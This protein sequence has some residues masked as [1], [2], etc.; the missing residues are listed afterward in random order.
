MVPDG[1][2]SKFTREIREFLMVSSHLEKK[3]NEHDEMMQE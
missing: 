3:V 1:E 2:L